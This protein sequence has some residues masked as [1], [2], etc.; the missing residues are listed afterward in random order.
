MSVDI[1]AYEILYNDMMLFGR[2]EYDNILDDTSFDTVLVSDHCH[3]RSVRSSVMVGLR[4]RSPYVCVCVRVHMCAYIYIYIY[5]HT[6]M[7]ILYT[8]TYMYVSIY[9]YIYIYTCKGP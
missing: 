6:H 1:A 2:S 5:I 8:H 7:Y 4:R 3:T 9:I